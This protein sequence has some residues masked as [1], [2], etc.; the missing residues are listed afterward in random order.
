MTITVPTHP[1]VLITDPTITVVAT[2]DRPVERTFQP[3]ILLE[4]GPSISIHYEL[5]PLPYVNNTWTDTD[6]QH[7]VEQHLATLTV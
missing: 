5:P 3:S 1:G 2:V 4:A 6:V 7:A